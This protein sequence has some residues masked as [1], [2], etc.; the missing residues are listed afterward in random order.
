M[1]SKGSY[2]EKIASE[3]RQGKNILLFVPGKKEIESNIEALRDILGKN[4][5]IFPLHAELPKDEQEFLLKKQDGDVQP[6]II[7]ATN[8]AEESITI[9]YID[10]VVD[11]GTHKVA[12]YNHL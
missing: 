6:R 8:V 10:L 2:F 5:Q 1:D 4:A 12:R 11:L 7:V 3:Y 9:D